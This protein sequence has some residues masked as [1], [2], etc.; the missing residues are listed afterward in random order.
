MW[1]DIDKDFTCIFS[2]EVTDLLKRACRTLSRSFRTY[3][4]L[5]L[6]HVDG[7]KIIDINGNTYIDFTSGGGNMLIRSDHPEIIEAISQFVKERKA[8][9]FHKALNVE[10]IEFVEEFAKISPISSEA[11]ALIVD[12][13]SEAVEAAIKIT[14]S[15]TGRRIIIGFTGSYHGLTLGAQSV[16]TDTPSKWK[17][18]E[19]APGFIHVPYPDC[20]NCFLH[21]K[22]GECRI[23]CLDYL[24]NMLELSIADNTAGIILQP[25]RSDGISP[26]EPY[27]KKIRELCEE[28]GILFIVDESIS[29]PARVGRWFALDYYGVSADCVVLSSQISQGFPLGL[30]LSKSRMLDLEPDSLEPEVGGNIFSITIA[31]TVLK[32]LKRDGLIERAERL[33]RL[34]KRR[35]EELAKEF[36]LISRIDGRGMHIG[37][38]LMGEDNHSSILARELINECFRNGLLLKQ[39]RKS[40]VVVSPP[41]DIEEESVGKGLEILEAKLREIYKFRRRL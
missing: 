24:T 18:F 12:S 37:F 9:S 29:A 8:F 38:K 10:L 20:S 6:K 36:E 40:T 31:L 15:Y 30:I 2:K 25:L 41:L 23:D 32:I 3:Y 1:G 27:V 4:P 17:R 13:K 22:R 35:L 14:R 33:G 16:S 34:I 21:N 11:R 19:P 5:I 39:D 7:E 28:N 26:P